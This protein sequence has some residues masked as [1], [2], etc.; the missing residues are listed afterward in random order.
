GG[1]AGR[2]V[3]LERESAEVT[4][5]EV[6]HATQVAQPPP[7]LAAGRAR[8]GGIGVLGRVDAG[9]QVAHGRDR[10]DRGGLL[11]RRGD[12]LG[13]LLVGGRLCLSRGCGHGLIAARL[14]GGL[15]G[16]AGRLGGRR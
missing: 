8:L 11:A 7:Y 12:D 1:A 3:D 9:R 10:R 14:R 2:A 5:Q 4:Q 15:G 16:R 13:R 6:A